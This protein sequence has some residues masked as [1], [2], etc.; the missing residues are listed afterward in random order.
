MRILHSGILAAAAVAVAFSAP[1]AAQPDHPS[2]GVGQTAQGRLES[3]DPVLTQ[4]G[5]FRVYQFRAEPGRRYVAWQES[6]DFDSY[7]A[8]A[9]TVRGITD[10][11]QADDDGG[12]GLNSRLRFTVP[13]AGTYLLIA[14]ALTDEGMGGFTVGLDTI[15]VVAPVVRDI[16]P[17]QTLRGEIT[18]GDPEDDAGLYHL[19]RFQGTAG[20]RVRAGFESEEIGGMVTI[21][22]M[23]G[24]RFV[25]I[26]EEGGWGGV[27]TITLPE[28]GTYHLRAGSWGDVGAYEV[29]LEDRPVVPLVTEP[30]QRGADANGAL[31]AGDAELDDGRLVDAYT[32]TAAAGEQVTITLRSEDF[33]AYVMVGRMENGAFV[34]LDRNDDGDEGLDSR[35]DFTVPAAGEYVVQATS[36]SAGGEGSYVLRVQP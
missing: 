6:D 30:L 32:F 26:D 18:D 2:L 20:Q 17:G 29:S 15:A 28:T 36:F 7:L 24:D 27:S 12:T 21:G 23:E 9:R 35:L 25:P 31:G 33:D 5:R 19:Y 1:A 13:E 8:V 3:G 22:R 16:A 10:V 14:Q 34:E 11:I 4:S